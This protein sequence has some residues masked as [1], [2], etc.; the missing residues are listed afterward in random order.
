MICLKGAMENAM[1]R[2]PTVFLSSLILPLLVVAVVAAIF[3][4]TRASA[5]GGKA[6]TVDYVIGLLDAGVSE[7]DIVARIEK[8]HLTFRVASGDIDRLMSAGATGHLVDAIISAGITLENREGAPAQGGTDTNGW[9]RPSRMG[10]Q[11]ETYPPSGEAAPPPSD[12][13]A[14][15]I[16]EMPDDGGYYYPGTS[17]YYPSYV[18]FGLSYGYPYYYPYYAYYPYYYYPAYHYGYHCNV[19]YYGHGGSG[20][21]YRTVPRGSGGGGSIHYGPRGGGGMTMAHGG[22]G[23]MMMPHGGGGGGHRSAPRGHH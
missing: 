10:T 4:P 21:G 1:K 22:G 9:G 5:Q 6:V 11:N 3:L 15:G 23:G 19:P 20:G 12:G 8:N 7:D 17:Y 14:E 16:E 18:S 2:N 13:H